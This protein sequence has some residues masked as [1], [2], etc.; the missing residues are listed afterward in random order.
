MLSFLLELL[1]GNIPT[2]TM[3]TLENDFN[4]VALHTFPWIAK[5]FRNL[6]PYTSPLTIFCP[7]L[8]DS[9]HTKYDWDYESPFIPLLG[10]S[11]LLPGLLDTHF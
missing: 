2:I 6:S 4:K 1:I 5:N 11:Y 8:W 7:A 3:G 10:H 9:V